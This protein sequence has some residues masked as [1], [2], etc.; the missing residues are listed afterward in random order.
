MMLRDHGGQDDDAG[1][2]QFTI[3]YEEVDSRRV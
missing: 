1:V 3:S 2:H